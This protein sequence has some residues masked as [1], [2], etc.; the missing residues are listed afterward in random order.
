MQSWTPNTPLQNGQYIIKRAI[1][2]GGFGETYLAED[3]E[4]NRLVVIKTLNREQ[5]EKPDFAEIQKRFRK[6]ALDLS[7][8]YHP[9]IV[10]VYDNF[11]EDGLW[12][13]VMEHIDGDDLA[14]YVENYT[15]EN[16][17]LSETEALRYIDQIGQALECV[18]E[19]KLLHR[20][21][22]P[23]NILLRRESK[24]AVLIDFGLAREFQP[25]KIRSM[26]AMITQGYAPIEQYER[27][28]DFGYYTDVYALAAT[29]YSLLTN[30]VPIPANYR[31][32]EDVKL[33]PPQKC[34]Q[35]ISDK[36]NTAILKGM[37]L[38]PVNRPQTVR[39][40]REL[41]GL[42]VKPVSTPQP[43]PRQQQNI[44]T[45]P[46]PLPQTVRLP[47]PYS[48]VPKSKEIFIPQSSTPQ[49]NNPEVELKSD[50]GMDYRKLPD[51]LKAGKWKEADEE[52]V[53]VMLVVAK[54]EKE[55]WLDYESIDNFPCEDLRTID[56]LW[57]KYSNGRFGFSVQKRIYQS[58][59]GT[60]KYDSDIWEKFGDKVGW[61]KGGNW[62]YYTDITFDKKAPEGHLPTLSCHISYGSYGFRYW[63]MRTF[64]ERRSF[65]SLA[66]RLL[67][68]NI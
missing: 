56:Q 15:A 30:R 21:V 31:A 27:R 12:A 1:G 51:L 10:Q 29:L 18:H 57:V 7:K 20:D 50:V 8:C 36:V 55:G 11:P 34:N 35:Q 28:G 53:R 67:S 24:E 44:P 68:C 13:I 19:R 2:G 25:G 43:Q 23:N 6:E 40:F 63:S 52:T 47:Q 60:R 16:G 38:E 45:P 32:E 58:F 66:S 48:F 65:S 46:P 5:R 59:G 33:S 14:A 64:T 61:R 41:L 39:E 42:V 62:L 37:E 4:E 3:T 22:K 54:R 9:H 26:T 17:Y 49:P